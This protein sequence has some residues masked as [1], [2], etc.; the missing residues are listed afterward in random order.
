MRVCRNAKFDTARRE[1]VPVRRT[2]A[3]VLRQRQVTNQQIRERVKP[4][5]ERKSMKTLL[6]AFSLLVCSTGISWA[7][8]LPNYG[9]NAPPNADSFGQPPSGAMP[10]GV[11]RSG[12]RA[13]PYLPYRYGAY[14]YARYRYARPYRGPPPYWYR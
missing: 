10:P 12:Y 7:Q 11:P 5:M 3:G 6:L 14:P 8:S 4:M 13:Y 9:P 2:E 1:V